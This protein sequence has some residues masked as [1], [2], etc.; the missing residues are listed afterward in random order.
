MIARWIASGVP[1]NPSS[2]VARVTVRSYGVGAGSALWGAS[3][4]SLTVLPCRLRVRL[5]QFSSDKGRDLKLF[6]VGLRGKV[7]FGRCLVGRLWLRLLDWLATED[8]K[9]T[10]L[11][12]S[13]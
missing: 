6:L 5:L 8:R 1:R 10:R 11:N 3:T 7:R 4:V 12:S 13:H 2:D 9:S